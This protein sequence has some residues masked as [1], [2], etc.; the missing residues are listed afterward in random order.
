MFFAILP[1]INALLD[2]PSWLVS[3]WLGRDLLRRLDGSRLRQIW[4]L[5]WHGVL[6]IAAAAIFLVLL[7]ALLPRALGLFFEIASRVVELPPISLPAYLC[8]AAREPLGAGLWASAM[9]FST[10][11]PTAL[12]LM[13]LVASPLAFWLRPTAPVW[14]E[15]AAYLAGHGAPPQS[16]LPRNPSLREAELK[17]DGVLRQTASKVAWWRI[18]QILLI[19]PLAFVVAL[20]LLWSLWR[21][22]QLVTGPLPEWLLWIATGDWAFV[23]ACLPGAF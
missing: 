15:R 12:H 2:W 1:L 7:A 21:L 17:R 20:G 10:L 9:L 6:D 14:V 23:E 18:R 11:V 4:G 16:D 13:F 19:Y 5:V 8:V 22:V 3:R